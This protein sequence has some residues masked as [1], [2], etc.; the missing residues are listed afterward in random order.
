ME[1]GRPVVSCLIQSL[2]VSMTIVNEY[3]CKPDYIPIGFFSG[4]DSS[5][6]FQAYV[7]AVTIISLN[8]K[9]PFT[10]HQISCSNLILLGS[11]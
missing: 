11:V 2:N 6:Y 7:Y 4:T 5:I 9:Y 8:A 1:N 3:A 10:N